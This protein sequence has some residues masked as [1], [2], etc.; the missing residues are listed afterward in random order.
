MGH[1]GSCA[2]S[3]ARQCRCG[4]CAGARHAWPG[5][6]GLTALSEAE[7]RSAL[8][9]AAE[10]EWAQG[11]QVGQRRRRPGRRKARAAVD[12]ARADI[13]EWLSGEA[14]G[15]SPPVTAAVN[16]LVS[17]LGDIVS[18]EVFTA[19]CQALGS[20]DNNRTRGDF[21]KKHLFCTLLAATA[22]SMQ[23]I[24][25]D[26][27]KAAEKIA[28]K[29]A[30]TCIGQEES[31][32]PAYVREIVAKVA[33]DGMAKLVKVNPAAQHFENFQQAVRIL[34]ILMCPAPE[35]HREVVTCC[36]KPLTEP[37]LTEE[38]QLQLK[39]AL[40]DWMR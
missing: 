1:T 13:C 14:M 10:R 31:G 5:T 8:R 40:P 23:K 19:L 27:N 25:D 35:K 4:G 33:V 39:E 38:V 3:K 11:D 28:A 17:Q 37:I 21:A 15:P 36:L 18:G 32:F 29:M 20:R 24:T 9:L 26:L 7:D 30:A 16:Q 6:L 34:A 12:L 2:E 22:C